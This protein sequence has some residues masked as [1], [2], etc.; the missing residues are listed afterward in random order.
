MPRSQS[1]A[2][3]QSSR[4]SLLR[5]GG[6]ALSVALGGSLAGCSLFGGE[7]RDPESTPSRTPFDVPEE[8][9]SP[10]PGTTTS[11]TTDTGSIVDFAPV[12]FP[13]PD[14]PEYRRWLPAP[15]ELGVSG[16]G[17]SEDPRYGYR[18][19]DF[20]QVREL[21]TAVPGSY[22]LDRQFGTLGLE[23][24]GIGVENYRRVVRTAGDRAVVVEAEI[25]PPSVATT[26]LD[27]GYSADGRVREYRVFSRDD[28]PRAVAVGD[29]AL[30]F[31]R[32]GEGSDQ[33]AIVRSVLDAAAGEVDRYHEVD[34]GARRLSRTVGTPPLG[35]V[36]PRAGRGFLDTLELDGTTGFAS[37]QAFD[38][39]ATY[40][41]YVFSFDGPVETEAV[42]EGLRQFAVDTG[43]F[44]YATA[45]EVSV[46]NRTARVAA[47]IDDE[48]IY[49]V[50]DFPTDITYP[51]VIWG[52]EQ[53]TD[54]E[55]TTVTITHEAGDEVDADLL[56]VDGGRIRDDPGADA[57]APGDSLTVVAATDTGEP[58]YVIRIVWQARDP[59]VYAVIGRYSLA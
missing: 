14:P 27:A 39:A 46:G 22:T 16:P 21:G 2:T 28:G 48:R 44:R 52:Y 43:D 29:D 19:V 3:V 40:W 49:Q 26:L 11:P 18:V 24:F 35:F 25:D 30:V 32:A 4:R 15:D 10:T 6:A 41:Q 17:D 54:G 20:E 55:D 50:F 23:Y 33:V 8:T 7:D 58:P 57:I 53:S 34:T 45:V 31:G 59:P 51:Q 42:R 1:S 38:D 12:P 13:E 36:N 9:A 47:S 56:R 37:S 5:R